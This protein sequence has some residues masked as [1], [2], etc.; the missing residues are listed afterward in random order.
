MDAW[1]DWFNR[2]NEQCGE[3]LSRIGVSTNLFQHEKNTFQVIH[4]LSQYFSVIEIE[5]EHEAR[6]LLQD[7]QDIANEMSKEMLA[8][9]NA[10][11]GK[12]DISVHAPYIGPNCNLASQDEHA[13]EKS[14]QQLREAMSFCY[15]VGAEKLTYHPGYVS[16]CS[17]ESSLAQ[18]RR[19]LSTL[20][21]N[22][23]ELGIKLCMENTGDNRPSYLRFS[24]E[25]YVDLCQTTGT[26]LTL[27]LI[28]HASL[29]S[30]ENR[31]GAAFFQSLDAMLPYVKN[32]H[33]ADMDIPRHVHLPIGEGNF[34]LTK[35]LAYIERKK[36]SGNIIIEEV[37]YGYSSQDFLKA[38]LKFCGKPSSLN[39]PSL[40]YCIH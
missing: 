27:D 30:E 12:I 22:A 36:Y 39:T 13:R 16:S 21:P 17:I 29:F 18:L 40:A 7:E 9:I 10:I 25:Q 5:L 28:H 6:R 8:D 23:S 2:E 37:G 14:C 19:S 33:V 26:Y 1:N 24:P 15:R 32:I 11:R 31:L 3:Y 4:E 35:V 20:V 38:A 34:P